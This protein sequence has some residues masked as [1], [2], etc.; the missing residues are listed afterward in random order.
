LM[1]ISQKL[2]TVPYRFFP[3]IIMFTIAAFTIFIVYT[4]L[5]SEISWTNIAIKILLLA[6]FLA[7]PF[8]LKLVGRQEIVYLVS[9][10]SKLKTTMTNKNES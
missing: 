5:M 8:G 1:A 2:Y 4:Y 3:N 7:I 9:I 10:V 6:G